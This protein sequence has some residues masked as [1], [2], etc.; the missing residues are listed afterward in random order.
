MRKGQT[1]GANTN[2]VV[3]APGDPRSP[4]TFINV[5]QNEQKLAA[6]LGFSNVAMLR[7]LA[8]TWPVLRAATTYENL[9]CSLSKNATFRLLADD[10]AAYSN[11]T[12]ASKWPIEEGDSAET[13]RN[14]KSRHLACILSAMR[15]D[16]LI[17]KTSTT[18][19]NRVSQKLYSKKWGST[20]E[21][22]LVF[23]P[24][25]PKDRQ[26]ATVDTSGG[27][28]TMPALG[29]YPLEHWLE[30]INRCWNLMRYLRHCH[31]S[32]GFWDRFTS[33]RINQAIRVD[34]AH[35]PS[36]MRP[37][38]A[39][40]EAAPIAKLAAVAAADALP[41]Q[42]VDIVWDKDLAFDDK[43]D[44]DE[45]LRAA[46]SKGVVI[47]ATHQE[48]A[49]DPRLS[50][51]AGAFRDSIRR[52]YN[53]QNLLID[54]RGL[55]LEYRNPKLAKGKLS[56]DLLADVW[57]GTKS[58]FLDPDNSGFLVRVT[59]RALED[60]DDAAIFESFEPPP[61]LTAYFDTSSGEVNERSDGID[62]IAAAAFGSADHR[63]EGRGP[64]SKPDIPHL[65]IAFT[66]GSGGNDI[67][68]A[69]DPT[70]KFKQPGDHEALKA[71]YGGHDV[72]TEQ[73]RLAF[74]LELIDAIVSMGRPNIK[75]DKLPKTLSTSQKQAIEDASFRGQV[76]AMSK[77][78]EGEV[79]D[80][81]DEVVSSTLDTQ[82]YF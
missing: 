81:D 1:R 61:A 11:V 44:L 76:M 36:W 29:P 75:L 58:T 40:A 73:G 48:A 59:F 27:E 42:Q 37:R 77:E 72:T 7:L 39:A 24:K 32:K 56:K 21:K 9:Q 12:P 26:R 22:P 80:D 41:R 50:P 17:I 3:D 16:F 68:S 43:A 82:K 19:H 38:E 63:Q 54:I 10:Q 55:E 62:S 35:T 5:E 66:Y 45:A 49:Q 28:V 25:F 47:P 79:G 67:G 52:Q 70:T 4:G 51:S 57:S 34:G 64:R 71:Y 78:G 8:V 13:R 18:H 23:E 20:F 69:P 30:G 15:A 2:S 53:C 6:Y 60:P 31:N 46:K 14:K 65:D 33:G 74:Q